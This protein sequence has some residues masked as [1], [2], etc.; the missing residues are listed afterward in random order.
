[1]IWRLGFDRPV[2]MQLRCRVEI[3]VGD[4]WTPP[5]T[6]RSFRWP[7]IGGL[8]A[9]GMVPPDFRSLMK[10]QG[11][12]DFSQVSKAEINAYLPLMKGDDRGRAF[13]KVSRSAQATA[14]KQELYRE[15]VGSRSYP[16]QIVWAAEDPAMPVGT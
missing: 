10:P 1:M 12:G 6:M 2:S 4:D 11:I 5:W 13:R 7:V 15:V 9:A 16:V 3:P 8:W 14:E